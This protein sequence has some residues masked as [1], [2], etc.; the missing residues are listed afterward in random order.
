MGVHCDCD[1]G[2]SSGQGQQPNGRYRTVLLL[3]LLINA[4]MFALEIGFGL[5]A[6]SSALLADALD[7]LGDAANYGISLWVLAMGVVARARASLLKA[8][9]MATFGIWVLGDALWGL[10]TGSVPQATTMGMVG[11]L[12]LFA[13]LTVAAMLYAWRNGDSNMRSVWLCTRNDAIGNVAV[14]LAALG[15]FGTGAG[16]PDLLVASIMAGLALTAAWQ[17]IRHARQELATAV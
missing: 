17:I 3:A 8:V 11:M 2:C 16:W 4:G 5:K 15:V 6:N 12:A 9:S 1:H 7:F 10:S 14:M 13:N